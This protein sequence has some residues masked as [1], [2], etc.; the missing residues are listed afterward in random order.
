RPGQQN[1]NE[2]ILVTEMDSTWKECLLYLPLY[3]SVD[4][5]EI[6]IG[7]AAGFEFVESPFKYNI[8][9][10]GTSIVQGASASR[11][12]LAY[13]ARLSRQ[14][15]LDFINL[16]I[17]GSAK[18]EPEVADMIANLQMDALIIDCVPNCSPD[19]I[20]ERTA[21]F[22]RIIREK[23]PGIPIITIEGALFE[24]G[25]F[26]QKTAADMLLRNHR[27]RQEITRLQQSDPHLYLIGAD[28]LMGDDHEGTID[29]THPND[30]GFDRMLQKI[31]PAT[32]NI[33]QQYNL[34]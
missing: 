31:R 26:N 30:L 20:T 3:D 28:G 16:G 4:Q 11:P 14:T 10:Y 23:Q 19:N 5:L 29:G 6:G 9:V 21:D 32:K 13:P 2:S 8:P 7:N 12:G 17:S 33:L 18:M 1:C 25:N 15:D 27:F 24:S 34:L 22:I